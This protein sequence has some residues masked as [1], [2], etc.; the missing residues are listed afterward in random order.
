[1]TKADE[2]DRS[3]RLGA[4]AVCVNDDAI[5]LSRYAAPD[6]R[7]GPPGGGVDHGEHPADGVVREVAEETGYDV[8]V[9][10]LLGVH[11]SVWR[12][13]DAEV[14]AAQVVY[15]VAVVGGELRHE[16]AGSTDQAAW[17]PLANLQTLRHTSFLD[18]ALDLYRRRPA[19]GRVEPVER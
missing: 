8:R 17:V 2:R 7:W 4:Y 10:S 19:S 14:H 15:E 11:S 5:L 12:G 6:C 1:M 13:S 9:V 16:I 18:V 3:Q